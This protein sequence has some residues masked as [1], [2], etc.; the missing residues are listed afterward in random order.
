MTHNR[1]DFE[2][3][4]RDFLNSNREHYGLILASRRSAHEVANRLLTILNKVIADEIKNQVRYLTLFTT[5]PE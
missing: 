5:F 4:A 3:L 1:A 2:F